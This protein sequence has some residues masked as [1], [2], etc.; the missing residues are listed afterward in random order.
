METLVNPIL[1]EQVLAEV[2]GLA[3]PADPQSAAARK[4]IMDNIQSA[5]GADLAEAVTIQAKHSA[6]FM[7]SKA[8]KSGVIG[9][10]YKKTWAV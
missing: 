3:A 10:A 8:C 4:A 5:C 9:L 2:S 7:T 6:G 1:P